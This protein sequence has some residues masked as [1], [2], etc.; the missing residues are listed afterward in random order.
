M[1]HSPTKLIGSKT[2]FIQNAISELGWKEAADGHQQDVSEAFCQITDILELPLLTL[3][4]D[5]F[6]DGIADAK[7]DHKRIYERLLQVA[8][9]SDPIP[10][11]NIRLEDCLE[12]FFNNKVE[13][14]RM[15][16]RSMS[17]KL[18]R[19]NTNSS[20]SSQKEASTHVEV[21]ELSSP[22]TP[23]SVHP[24][25][26]PLAQTRIR[27]QS[28][29][30]RRLVDNELGDSSTADADNASTRSSIRKQ[31]LRKEVSLP[32]WYVSIPGIIDYLN[33]LHDHI[34]CLYSGY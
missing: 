4:V 17:T 14:K 31:S 11:Q 30:R 6:H 5:L 13:V 23:I 3:K 25:A 12:T 8:I 22:S 26:T 21:A 1:S 34:L 15:L 32:A 7:D 10:G 19:S 24:P 33:S 9:P 16:Q 28:I 20:M 27:A 29:I 2:T 18:E